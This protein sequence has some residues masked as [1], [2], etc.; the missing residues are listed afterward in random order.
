MIAKMSKVEIIG[1]REQLLPVL[2]TITALGT[3]QVDADIQ[4]RMPLSTESRLKALPLD[5][6]TLGERL[7]YEDLDTRVSRLLS[8]L[9]KSEARETSLSAPQALS[10]VATLVDERIAICE[11]KTRRRDSLRGD[12]NELDRTMVFLSTVESLAPKGAEAAGLEAIA[13]QVKDRA[14]LE[15]LTRVAGRLLLGAEVQTARSEDGSYIG[16]LTTEKQLS[17]SLK[18]ALRDNQIPEVS[19]PPYLQGLSLAEKINAA[20]SRYQQ[21]SAEAS[22]IERELQQEAEN[23]R[24]LYERIHEWL[25]G[26]L[27]LLKITAQA[28]ATDNCFV[29]FGWMKSGDVPRLQDSLAKQYGGTVIVE[30][31]EILEHD[32]ETV[33]V[34]LKNPPYLK[35]FELLVRLLPLPRY[36]SIDPTP[37]I[38]IFFPLFFGMILGDVGYGLLLLLVAV[39]LIGFAKPKL[40]QDAGKILAFSSVYAVI[41]GML[42]GEFFGSYRTEILGAKTGW[43]DRRTSLMPMLYFAIAVGSVHVALG[44]ILGVLSAIKARR[45]KEAASRAASLLLIVCIAGLLASY[46]APVGLLIRRPLMI[47]VMIIIPILLVT[48]GLLAPFELLRSLG[49]IISY[50]RIMAVGLASVLLA[51]VANNLAGAAGSIWVG[52]SVAVLLHAFNLLLG[53]FAPTIHA[54]RLHYVEFFGKFLESGGKQYR[55]LTKAH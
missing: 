50:A 22:A 49:N 43:I 24:P 33:P 48:G 10:A 14:A 12:L 53:V 20:R 6:K 5:A 54:L 26:Q 27:A 13:V 15:H 19:L 52:V 37:F 35:P 36:T 42:Y 25:D 17:E 44:L 40:V 3:L 18:E 9:P 46:F 4:K 30:V 51:Y 29:L 47:A 45:R 32:L 31:R 1:P 38:G 7:F 55:P 2:E 39:L 23:W 28:Y 21:Q 41:F 8:L 11:E 16:L 34:T